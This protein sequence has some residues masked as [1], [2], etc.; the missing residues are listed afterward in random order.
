MKR[1]ETVE[2]RDLVESWIEGL[3]QEGV[4]DRI[5]YLR[6]DREGH[7]VER[8]GAVMSS[9]PFSASRMADELVEECA[10]VAEWKKQRTSFRFECYRKSEDPQFHTVRGAQK[11]RVFDFGEGGEEFLHEEV[12]ENLSTQREFNALRHAE[13]MQEL[14]VSAVRELRQTDLQEKTRLMRRIE[15]LENRAD[16][17]ERAVAEA[18]E[19]ARRTEVEY[20]KA[21]REDRIHQLGYDMLSLAVPAIASKALPSGGSAQGPLEGDLVKDFFESMT[22]KQIRTFVT[23]AGLD[24]AQ[25]MALDALREAYQK[26]EHPALADPLIEKFFDTLT[27]QQGELF[28]SILRPEQL[29]QFGKIVGAYYERQQQ[30]K[31]AEAAE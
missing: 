26:G 7:E 25:L 23:Q 6:L 4:I 2:S 16:A 5:E 3:A 20:L 18:R 22:P 14:S 15:F 17:Q 27:P 21:K 10:R 30:R 31:A 9:S 11:T 13:R 1:N 19:K 24:P 29:E 12:R 8:C 28:K